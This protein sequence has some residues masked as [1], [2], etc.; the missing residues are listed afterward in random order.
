MPPFHKVTLPDRHYQ[1][2]LR[3]A[4]SAFC[5]ALDIMHERA[6]SLGA[7]AVTRRAVTPAELAYGDVPIKIVNPED[8]LGDA[9]A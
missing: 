7:Y 6:K 8:N 9:P 2:A 1:V 5:D 4:L 3:S